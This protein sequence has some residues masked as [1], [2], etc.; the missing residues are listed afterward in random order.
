[1]RLRLVSLIL[2][3]FYSAGLVVQE[4]WF[5]CIYFRVL[6]ENR[7]VYASVTSVLQESRVF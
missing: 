3:L 5:S 7:E 1:M 6:P 2:I 4:S